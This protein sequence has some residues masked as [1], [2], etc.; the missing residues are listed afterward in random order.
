VATRHAR[1]G[2]GVRAAVEAWGLEFFCRVP[3]ARSDTVTALVMPPG[4]DADN[5]RHVILDRFDMSLG[6]GL[7]TFAGRVLRIGHLG[8]LND[9]VMCGTLAGLEMGMAIA[10]VPHEPGGIAVAMRHLARTLR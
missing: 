2:A 3:G 9:L 6:A 4:H 1:H 10:G 7:G 8:D 5:L